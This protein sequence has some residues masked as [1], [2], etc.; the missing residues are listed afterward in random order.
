ME[1]SMTGNCLL[2]NENTCAKQV[3]IGRARKN[4]IV[5]IVH[6]FD[7]SS[8]SDNAALVYE[9][10]ERVIGELREEY[11]SVKF[12]HN[13]LG[14]KDGSIYCDICRQIKSA[15]VGLFDISTYNLNVIFEL[16]LA[17][18]AGTY[19]FILRSAHYHRRGNV[20]SDLNGIL[21]YRFS[22]RSGRL[23]FRAN[24]RRSLKIKLRD[25]VE[26]RLKKRRAN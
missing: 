8:H 14:A 2:H 19:V 4:N 18:G 9:E 1:T 7:W 5:K 10:V 22:R 6:A 20:P 23:S 26:R 3:S 12:T 13:A 25:A 21:E 11:P 24:F 17:I 15:D 16:G